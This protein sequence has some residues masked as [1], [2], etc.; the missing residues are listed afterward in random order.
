MSWYNDALC[1]ARNVG[2]WQKPWRSWVGWR[3]FR[4]WKRQRLCC[5]RV[6]KHVSS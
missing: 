5:L 3:P 4:V 6:C 2:S 1:T